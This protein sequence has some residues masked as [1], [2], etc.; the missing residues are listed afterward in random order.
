MNT[1]QQSAT[2]KGFDRQTISLVED[3]ITQLPQVTPQDRNFINVLFRSESEESKKFAE[4]KL[5]LVTTQIEYRR[6]ALVMAANLRIEELRQH[7][8]SEAQKR[9]YEFKL[10]TE[11]YIRE[12][13]SEREVW[14]NREVDN[15]LQNYEA[16]VE[17]MEKIRSP[18]AKA[19]EQ[20]R[21]DETLDAFYDTITHFNQEFQK[22]LDFQASTPMA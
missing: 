11:Q 6:Q 9:G 8:E 22:S 3:Q 18:K 4:A 16:A 17:R 7:C 10:R 19:K 21:L 2:T 13:I 14:A 20:E 5:A 12:L 1:E 15:F